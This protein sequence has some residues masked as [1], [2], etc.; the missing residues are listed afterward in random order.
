M[1]ISMKNRKAKRPQTKRKPIGHATLPD[2]L[3][4]RIKGFNRILGD[5]GE[6]NMEEYI[7]IL[8]LHIHPEEAIQTWENIAVTY[9]WYILQNSI[10]DLAVRQGVLSVIVGV[11]LGLKAEDFGS[12]AA[13]RLM[14]Q[15]WIKPLAKKQI[16]DI[17]NHCKPVSQK[18]ET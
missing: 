18:G 10:T 14:P 6:A 5:L 9:R 16:E 11:S 2:E 8:S 4:E 17:V 7:K 12:Q 13:E 15:Q 3:V 1:S